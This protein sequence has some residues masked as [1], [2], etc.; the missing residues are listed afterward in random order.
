MA[1]STDYSG[2]LVDVLIFQGT[3]PAGMVPVSLS[4]GSAG[5]LTTGI[6]KVSQSF[7]MFFLMDKGSV[8]AQPDYGTSF[9]SQFRLG[10]LRDESSVKS[11]FA[12][13]SDATVRALRAQAAAAN[14]P[15]DETIKSATLL[16]YS[17]DKATGNLQLRIQLTSDAGATRTVF[18]PIPVTIR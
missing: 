17:L 3:Q 9:V 18:L 4:F 7:T 11:A 14:L 6:Q 5:Y 16:G 15:A 12:F 13:A 8:P 10:Y 2:R 1:T